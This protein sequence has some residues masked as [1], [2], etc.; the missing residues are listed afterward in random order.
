MMGSSR[1]SK[2]KIDSMN[3]NN[4]VENNRYN[5]LISCYEEFLNYFNYEY[6]APTD[7]APFGVTTE[8]SDCPWNPDSKLLLSR[9]ESL[10]LGCESRLYTFCTETRRAYPG[11]ATTARGWSRRPPAWPWRRSRRALF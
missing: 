2:L 10:E 3:I 6:K 8:M 7:D 11:R 9:V 5:D 4:E 1:Y